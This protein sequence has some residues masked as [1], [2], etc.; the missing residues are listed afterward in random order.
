MI[1]LYQNLPNYST[2]LT[3]TQKTEYYLSAAKTKTL[4]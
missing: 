1:L 3:L 4:L 2:I